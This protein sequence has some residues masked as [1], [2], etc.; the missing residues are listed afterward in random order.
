M[1]K[2]EL[3]KVDRLESH[4]RLLEFQKQSDQ[5]GIEVQKCID[6]LPYNKPHPFYVWGHSRQISIDERMAYFMGG[7]YKNFED[8]PSEK[9]LWMPRP[10]KPEC[11]PN[12]YLFRATKGS[13]I[14]EIVWML[15]KI[16]F[17]DMFGPGKMT[18]NPDIY[19]SILN[20]KYNRKELEYPQ[21]GDM[22][23]DQRDEFRE[24]IKQ[25]RIWNKMEEP[26]KMI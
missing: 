22:N 6:N 26:Y 19:T 25:T 16:E 21:E 18:H 7:C 14:V 1:N 8:V 4:D 10:T 20:F 15:P 24:C 9:F 11:T 12:S 3:Q 2:I 5:I 17:W 13:D 23:I